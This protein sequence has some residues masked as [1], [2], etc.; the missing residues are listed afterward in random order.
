LTTGRASKV[1]VKAPATPASPKMPKAIDHPNQLANGAA[2]ETDKAIPRLRA[3]VL[4]AFMTRISLC[5][6]HCIIRG[7][8]AVSK[9]AVPTPN[10]NRSASSEIKFGARGDSAIRAISQ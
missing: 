9:N 7:P 4:N 3:A 6:N 2:V 5:L 1:Q 10:A 8:V